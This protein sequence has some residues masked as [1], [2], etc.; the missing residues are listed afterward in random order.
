MIDYWTK[1]GYLTCVSRSRESSGTKRRYV[2]R[3]AAVAQMMRLLIA[4]GIEPET[5]A[6][7]GRAMVTHNVRR[8]A[9]DESVLVTVSFPTEVQQI[10]P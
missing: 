10:A 2:R 9:L 7:A 3:E 8:I 1:K 5:A 6:R 4:A